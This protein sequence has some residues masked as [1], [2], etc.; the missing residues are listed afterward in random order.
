MK[1][2]HPDTHPPRFH[3]E[4]RSEWGSARR[5]PGW[6]L[7][8]AFPSAVSA[9]GEVTA[10]SPVGKH[11]LSLRLLC[12]LHPRRLICLF[13]YQICGL[14]VWE[15]GTDFI[16]KP[17]HLLLPQIDTIHVMLFHQTAFIPPPVQGLPA[18]C[19]LRGQFWGIFY[20]MDWFFLWQAQNSILFHKF[21]LIE[22]SP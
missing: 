1:R 21:I 14:A 5:F 15:S 16:I 12:E 10:R 4:V 22:L 9:V 2:S 11:L 17:Q 18:F 8:S 6:I 7:R 3:C 13:M 20:F 19:P